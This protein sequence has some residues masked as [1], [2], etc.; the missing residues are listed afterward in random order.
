MARERSNELR[1]ARRGL[2]TALLALAEAEGPPPLRSALE[3][4]CP[5]LIEAEP[6]DP[7]VELARLDVVDAARWLLRLVLTDTDRA[8]VA[9]MIHATRA[10]GSRLAS[11]A[12]ELTHPPLPGL[13]YAPTRRER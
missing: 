8:E 6:V 1:Q 10:T 13:D 7:A 11:H 5:E 3:M 12:N 9:A 2:A 4:I